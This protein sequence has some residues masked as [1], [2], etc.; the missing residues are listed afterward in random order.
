MVAFAGVGLVISQ[1]VKKGTFHSLDA[2]CGLPVAFGMFGAL[3]GAAVAILVLFRR[4]SRNVSSGMPH[5]FT[6]INGMGSTLIGRWEPHDDGSY[7]TTEWLTVLW[8]PIVPVCT[9][10]IIK[11]PEPNSFVVAA[12]RLLEKHPVQLK[13]VW[14]GLFRTVVLAAIVAVCGWYL[15]R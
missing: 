15:S 5:S 1:F 9:Y 8:V 12:Y 11:L 14:A 10:R 3:L 6:S 2:T 7:L 4:E 13:Y